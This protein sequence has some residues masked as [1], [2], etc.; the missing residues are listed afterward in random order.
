M[1]EAAAEAAALPALMGDG[2]DGT[3]SFPPGA[4]ASPPQA[5]VQHERDP[6]SIVG[7]D[8]IAMAIPT[9]A[10]QT[11][12]AEAHAARKEYA[13]A[14]AAGAAKTTATDAVDIGG[15]GEVLGAAAG[16]EGRESV[17]Q[18]SGRPATGDGAPTDRELKADA[19]IKLAPDTA[20]DTARAGQIAVDA[21]KAQWLRNI[22]GSLPLMFRSQRAIPLNFTCLRRVFTVTCP[23]GKGFATADAYLT[24]VRQWWL[25][26]LAGST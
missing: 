20:R 17:A 4:G 16:A 2:G 14:A 8:A 21:V 1:A 26:R 15:Q 13:A 7:G 23:N 12:A 24:L 3:A 5:P 25:D 19:L 10:P 9:A 6:S 18:Q 22:N 11:R